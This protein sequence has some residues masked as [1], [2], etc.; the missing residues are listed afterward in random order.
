MDGEG[1]FS[2]IWIAASYALFPF[3]VVSLPEAVISNFLAQREGA[4]LG[5]MSVIANGWSLIFLIA[6]M[7]EI[8]QFSLKKTII[9]M[10]LTVLGMGVIIFLGVLIFSL[11]QQL[12]IFLYTVYSEIKFRL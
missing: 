9:S 4:F 3:I 7:K 2:E 11:F 8:H 5:M 1:R 6:A 10:L 12:F